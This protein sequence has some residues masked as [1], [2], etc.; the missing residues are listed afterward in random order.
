MQAH[1]L[2][3]VTVPLLCAVITTSHLQTFS[4]LLLSFM[5][6][7]SLLGWVGACCL[8][9]G[10]L[11]ADITWKHH[12]SSLYS[13]STHFKC[14]FPSPMAESIHPFFSQMLV[15]ALLELGGHAFSRFLEHPSF[16]GLPIKC[17][18]DDSCL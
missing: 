8:D 13:L 18:T 6:D 9:V 11:A 14:P 1:I 2:N 12:P 3:P 17:S 7:T 4:F 10:R 5:R 16:I 15:P